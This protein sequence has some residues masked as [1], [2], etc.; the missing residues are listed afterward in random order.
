MKILLVG[1]NAKFSH[2]NLA[3]KYIEKYSN[4]DDIKIVEFNINQNIE[5]IYREII[6]EQPDIVGFSTYIWNF[7]FVKRL[8]SDLKK[9]MEALVI[10]WGGPEVSFDTRDLLEENPSLD[11]IIRDEG[12]VTS[13][14]LFETLEKKSSLGDILGISYRH[15][16]QIFVNEDRPLIKDLDSLPSPFLDYKATNGRM[17]YFEMSRGCPF[18]CSYCLSS[19]ICG[20]RTFSLDR[21]KRDLVEIISSG[22]QVVK[23]VDRTFNANEKFSMEVMDFILENKRDDLV[24]HMELMAHLISDRFLDYLKD[25]PRGLFQFEIGIQSGN[26]KTLNEINRK[27]D[28][29]RLEEVVKKIKSFNNIHQH[30]D[31]IVGLPFEGYDSFRESFNFA[32]KLGVE[33][34]QLGFLK[35]LRGS[36]L[37]KRAHEYDIVFSD[38][39][40]YEV[41]S[42]RWLSP[43]EISKLKVIEDLVEKFSNE[44]Y[45]EKTLE[46]LVPEENPFGFFEDFGRFWEEKDYHLSLHSRKSLYE[47]L[48][49]FVSKREDYEEVLENLR[50]DFLKNNKSQPKDFLRPRGIGVKDYH[51]LLKDN[52]VREKFSLGDNIPTKKLVK[53]FAFEVFTFDGQEK[54]LGFYY[55][56]DQTLVLDMTMDYE[57]IIYGI[58]K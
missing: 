47:R 55:K 1:I 5:D 7:N 10:V 48:S 14:V 37:R 26:E 50:Y 16:G 15:Q 52:I 13:K 35:L 8:T 32:Y 39:P 56:E 57:R 53:D 51:D 12:E 54:V 18:S 38:Y 11:I 45:F 25:L 21:I 19:T 28:L 31:L 20:L 41:I 23:L 2:E 4:R 30:V 3:I 22:V 42:T 44:D 33:K 27:T 40:P 34:L 29:G 6:K 24:F 43:K 46:Y 9:A 58:R 49:G 17:V 36:E